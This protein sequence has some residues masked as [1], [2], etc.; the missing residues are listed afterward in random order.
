MACASSVPTS[1]KS[2]S[3]S[4]MLA[5][6]SQVLSGPMPRAWRSSE[7][8]RSRD[9]RLRASSSSSR[10]LALPCCSSNHTRRKP[11]SILDSFSP[12]FPSRAAFQSSYRE[13]V[14]TPMSNSLVKSRSTPL[15]LSYSPS[16]SSIRSSNSSLGRLPSRLRS[17]A[18]YAS[19]DLTAGA[20]S[21][22]RVLMVISPSSLC[23]AS[24]ALKAS[25]FL[26]SALRASSLMRSFSSFSLRSS[27][28]MYSWKVSSLSSLSSASNSGSPSSLL[29]TFRHSLVTLMPGVRSKSSLKAEVRRFFSCRR[30][31]FSRPAF[32]F[33]ASWNSSSRSRSGTAFQRGF[34]SNS[35]LALR[36]PWVVFSAADSKMRWKKS[37]RAALNFR[38]SSS[39]SSFLLSWMYSLKHCFFSPRDLRA[40][41]L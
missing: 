7:P 17:T 15:A 3:F 24:S 11:S 5:N 8:N 4:Y 41:Y 28:L 9:L 29:A 25:R 1:L 37:S 31:S 30:S 14:L 33:C 36:K 19:S 27:S 26:R 21:F 23:S 20:Y 32:S 38:R 6:D 39:F 16:M 2:L 12:A 40:P 13:V 22:Q 34:S 18:R 10:T 35:S